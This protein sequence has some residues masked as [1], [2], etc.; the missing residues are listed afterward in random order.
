MQLE[1]KMQISNKNKQNKGMAFIY[2]KGNQF[3]TVGSGLMMSSTTS[4]EIVSV[5]YPVLSLYCRFPN[6]QL[7]M[8]SSL[9]MKAVKLLALSK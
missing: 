7:D 3:D 6:S 9:T 8:P 4:Y 5:F 1:S 2:I